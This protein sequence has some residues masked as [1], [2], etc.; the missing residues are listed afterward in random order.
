[1]KIALAQIN[2]VI[3]DL[4]G[5]VERC[6]KAAVQATRQGADLVLFPSLTICG[7]SPR[8]IFFDPGFVQAAGEAAAD[9]AERSQHLAPLLISNIIPTLNKQAFQ[10]QLQNAALWIQDG[11]IRTI[12][13]QS[14][15]RCDDVYLEKRWFTSMPITDPIEYMEKKFGILVGWDLF[16][17]QKITYLRKQGS[18]YLLN[19]GAHAFT[20]FSL[21]QALDAARQCQLPVLSSNLVGGNDELIFAGQSFT[22]NSD[23]NP[24]YIMESFQEDIQVFHLETVKTHHPTIL[25]QPEEQLIKALTLGVR[26]FFTKN[27]L[28]FA[29]LGISGGIDSALVAVLAAQALGA[30]NVHAVAMPSRYTQP[31]STSSAEQLCQTQGMNFHLH[32]IETLHQAFESDLTE[33]IQNGTGAENVQARLRA[34]ILMAY[35]NHYGGLLINTSNKTELSLGYGTAYGDLAGTLSPIGDLTKTQ[36][37]RLARWINRDKEIIPEFILNRLPSAELRPNQVD[38][39]DYADISPQVEEIVQQ[40]RATPMMRAAESKRW[41][42]GVVLKVSEKAFGSGRLIPIT[43]K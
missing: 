30:E 4:E 13:G 15:L 26:D 34:V 19:L 9:L 33:L 3:A 38:P 1:M 12:G 29:F 14:L 37:Y 16:D 21:T 32:P 2:P 42:L 5:N 7:Y 23:S 24:G 36:V 31:E 20:S 25:N 17:Q 39:F 18:Q 27:N 11:E 40:N 41:Q 28:K 8:D 35:V 22:I 43:K 6:L 10:P